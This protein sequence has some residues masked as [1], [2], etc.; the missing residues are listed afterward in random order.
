MVHA[1]HRAE[2]E[3]CGWVG[4]SRCETVDSNLHLRHFSRTTFISMTGVLRRYVKVGSRPW[5]DSAPEALGALANLFQC[6]FK[7][8]QLFRARIGKDPF[9][10]GGVF[11]KDRRDQ[12]FAFWCERHDADAPILRTLDPAYQAPFDEAVHGRAD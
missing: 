8:S 2:R 9:N 10:F 7:S 4:N 3:T 11:P 5:F 6:R 1:L 12:S